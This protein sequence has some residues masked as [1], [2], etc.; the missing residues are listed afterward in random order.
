MLKFLTVFRKTVE[1]GMD[2]RL[3]VHDFHEQ[4]NSFYLN[5]IYK[6]QT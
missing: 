5:L 4:S 6:M 2:P 1:T 3:H